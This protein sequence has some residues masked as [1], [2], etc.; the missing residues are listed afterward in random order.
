MRESED[1]EVDGLS[2]ESVSGKGDLSRRRTVIVP[3][4]AGEEDAELR[5][6]VVVAMR[7]LFAEV[8]DDGVIVPCTIRRVLRTRRI[9]ERHPVTVGDCVKFRLERGN[10]A[11][12]VEGV[13][14]RVEPRHGRLQR[15]AGRRIQTIVANIDNVIIVSSANAP[16]PKL[17][18]IDRYIV[19]SLAE[20]MTPIICI[21][22]MDLDRDDSITPIV[23]RYE[24]LGQRIIRTS[25]VTGRGMDELRETLA[26]G[27][28]VIVGQS[29]VGKSSLLNAIQ[30]GLNLAIGDINEQLQC[31][32]HTTTTARLLRLD[33]G[34]YVVDTPGIRSF[35]LSIVPRGELEAYFVE[36]LDHIPHCK[37]PDCTHRHEV[38]CAVKEAVEQGLI[39][40]ERY[41]SYVRIFEDPGSPL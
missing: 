41:E 6:G 35:D 17:N 13:I 25:V 18:L 26:R 11:G 40:R 8:D 19:A 20:D 9:K 36:F 31:G 30:P 10:S 39:H 33:V 15:R 5:S 22:K 4:D 23:E 7:G 21:N 37:F 38:S 14:E 1:G 12:K 27:S 32:R 2:T 16:P 24:S 34:G 3:D 28:S 29:G